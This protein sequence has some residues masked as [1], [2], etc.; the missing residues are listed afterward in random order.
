[1]YDFSAVIGGVVKVGELV[2][3]LP[4][5]TSDHWY[6]MGVLSPSVAVTCSVA[7]FPTK[8]VVL[9]GGA[10]MLGGLQTVT[11]IVLLV[12]TTGVPPQSLIAL[13]KYV[14]V[15]GGAK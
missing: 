2:P 12:A 4:P 11:V 3:T 13:K 9:A 10:S 6:V 14:S 1:M 7:V 15:S 8:T 5:P